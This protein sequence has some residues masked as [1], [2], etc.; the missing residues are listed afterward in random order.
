MAGNKIYIQVDFQAEG[1]TAAVNKLNEQIKSVGTTS[2]AATKQ[3]ESG[4]NA[5]SVSISQ[6]TR[7]LDQIAQ[8][9]AGL[10]VAR[11]LGGMVEAADA[12]S[13]TRAAFQAMGA[14]ADEA[15]DAIERIRAV[16][17]KSPLS[18]D[19]LR[20]AGQR[21]KGFGFELQEIPGLLNAVTNATAALGKGK[22]GIESITLAL[23]QMKA[24]GIIQGQEA[25]RQLAEQGINAIKYLQPAI[26][27]ELGHA[28]SAM[29]VRK[30]IEKQMIGAEAGVRIIL[31]G[32]QK[33][34][35]KAGE[36]MSKLP[37]AQMVKLLDDLKQLG[38][39]IA[40]DF[41]PVLLSVI[42]T[43]REWLQF[44]M[45]M[46]APIRDTATALGVLAVAL[47]AVGAAA[48][49]G[50]L[51][52]IGPAV[53]ALQ[54][55]GPALMVAVNAMTI[56]FEGVE[57]LSVAELAAVTA[58]IW[59]MIPAILAAGA[60]WV[61]YQAYQE[62]ALTS[63]E[64][65]AAMNKAFKDREALAI[66]AQE[67]EDIFKATG[68]KQFGL[69][70]SRDTSY[71]K[72][73]IDQLKEQIALMK[74][75]AGEQAKLVQQ[76]E[77]AAKHRAEI[78]DQILSRA[79][80]RIHGAIFGL[81]DKYRGAL[82]E[83][84]G[85]AKNTAKVLQAMGLDLEEAQK[86]VAEDNIK[87]ID[88]ANAKRIAGAKVLQQ[89]F[90][91]YAKGPTAAYKKHLEYIEA[92]DQM[93]MDT[94]RARLAY[95]QTAL[96]ADRD[97]RIAEL[98]QTHRQTLEQEIAYQQEVLEIRTKYAYKIR[99][100]EIELQQQDTNRKVA[101][102]EVLLKLKLI[103]EIDYAV[104]VAALQAAQ[105]QR[106]RE[107]I[108]NTD[109]A[110]SKDRLETTKKTNDAII[111]EQKKIYDKL[112]G[113]LDRV[114]DALLNKSTSIWQA[115]ANGFKTAI[116]GAIKEIVTSRAA[117]ALM[118]LF[119]Y[120]TVS[121]GGGPRGLGGQ[122]PIF[123]GG[124]GGSP[125]GAGGILAALFGARSRGFGAPGAPGGTG[126]F[127][128]PVGTYG[129]YTG[130]YS[131]VGGAAAAAPVAMPG[132]GAT[133][134]ALWPAAA[135]LGGG[136][137]AAQGIQRGGKIGLGQAIGGAGVAGAGLAHLAP[138]LGGLIPGLGL[139][140]VGGGVLGAGIGLAGYGLYRGGK[141]GI[142]LTAG[143]GALIGAVLGTALFPG[144]GTL[145]G[146]GIGAA[147]GG[148]AGLF[149][150]LVKTAD[151]KLQ[152][153][154]KS[155]YGVDVQDK[156]VRAQILEIAKQKY[157]GNLDLA[158]RSPE[159]QNLVQLYALTTAQNPVGMPQ[160]MYGATLAQSG[161]ALQLQPVYSNGQMVA[162]PYSSSSGWSAGGVY[163]QLNP[164]QANDLFEGRV[165]NAISS[166]PDTVGQAA[167]TSSR[168][169][170][171]R[172]AQRSA[173]LEPLTVVR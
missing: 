11:L 166:N 144:I 7:G 172:D 25:F 33:E 105:Q 74:Q 68:S 46:P 134:S 108:S 154:L 79:Q 62:N 81:T 23:G 147:V 41:A 58:A 53:A 70:A 76:S 169:G 99:D 125:V 6:T 117:A 151:Q 64:R 130:G 146:A 163:I 50:L 111:D 167:A 123:G 100:V 141:A 93:E 32:M 8:T 40:K 96:A 17:A 22:V 160:K 35:G 94:L 119:G 37:T 143:G 54:Q 63:P 126:G 114:F 89:Y 55:L 149:R 137:L 158:I 78:A 30:M 113:S 98:E 104:T 102:Q 173:L 148:I 18:F 82:A 112:K 15:N 95:E 34:F 138:T 171:S 59:A 60:A 56:L 44:F 21:L 162:N 66:Q 161:G 88:D 12:I 65:V 29:D 83:L 92:A 5:L 128:G 115:I 14:S 136:Y 26:A 27:A 4:F 135:V 13:R 153:K 16:A 132:F 165:V 133:A 170:R 67:M 109:I 69:G 121:F 36:A 131:P 120:G 47:S 51:S 116:I 24:K 43:M 118:Q 20:D 103:N 42:G 57:A 84:A 122:Q 31:E 150:S 129:G 142:G 124:G 38:A 159:I 87:L 28:V 19:E 3:A 156:G 1:A 86:K 107:I 2:Q 145:L 72:M 73:T 9:F 164:Q 85:D 168:S 127:T 110:I 90:E 75:A 77:E 140:A 48:K 80:A 91:D 106:I 97:I 157:G 49:L 39:A 139:S 10:G 71:Q 61:A 152:T 155:V 52:W 101:D 45:E